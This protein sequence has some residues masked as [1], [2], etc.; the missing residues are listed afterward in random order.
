ML[1]IYYFLK[2]GCGLLNFFF[3]GALII[4]FFSNTHGQYCQIYEMRISTNPSIT[5]RDILKT[6]DITWYFN[7]KCTTGIFANGDY[8]VLGPVTIDSITPHYDGSNNGWE[9]NPVVSGGHGF[10]SGCYGAGF[11]STLVPKLPFYADPKIYSPDS[12]ISIVKTT[13]STQGR[14]CIKCAEVI[15]IVNK[16]PPGNGSLVFR[17]PYVGENKPYYFI[18]SIRR[19]LLPNNF[20]PVANM[21]SLEYI[22]KTFSKLRMD[23]KPGRMGV[24]LRPIQSN[25]SDY[26][27]ENTPAQ[28]DAVLR[29]MMNDSFE[30]KLPALINFLQFGID[31]VHTMLD[32]QTWPAGGGHQPGHLV[33]LAFTAVLL[34]MEEIKSILKNATFFHGSKYFS[35]GKHGLTLWGIPS[36]EK[37]YWNY[38]MNTKGDRSQRDPYRYIDGGKP[39]SEYQF[40]TA[41]SH[42]GEILATHL[43]PKLKEAWNPVE[44]RMMQNYTDRW[45]LHGAWT[46]PDPYAP[47]DGIKENYG[48]T[49][50][51]DSEDSG[52]GIKG[53]GR[54][55]GAHGNARDDGQ[56]KSAYVTAMWKAYRK[57]ASDASTTPPFV[58]IT[59]PLNEKTIIDTCNITV[60]AFGINGIKS[61]HFY[62]NDL[63]LGSVSDVIDIKTNKYSL[64]LDPDIVGKG[65]HLISVTATD[66]LNNI[67][68]D[69]IIVYYK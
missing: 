68:S 36:T 67:N 46:I 38:F 44:W 23:H 66:S 58:I 6:G 48:L 27:P 2:K 49:F 14:Q 64:P 56:Y 26:Q 17:P 31:K 13:V 65:N 59:N 3:F 41:Q 10:Q 18:K 20:M 9:I 60:S 51:P 22:A 55:P 15:T 25:M 4:L 53:T 12:I 54:F 30:K 57:S 1:K 24:S 62:I 37:G 69:T 42:K 8:W 39:S 63:L 35:V 7:S 61:V 21:P 32:G 28:N 52:N 33:V 11:D 50:G 16:V 29:F 40:I 45:V 47:Y 5:I 43:M 19:D 34:D